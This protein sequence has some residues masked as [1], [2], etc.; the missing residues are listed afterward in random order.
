VVHGISSVSTL[1]HPDLHVTRTQAEV[2]PR[3]ISK[4]LGAGPN[5]TLGVHNGDINTLERALLERMYFCKVG[6]GFSPA[7]NPTYR[8]IDQKLGYF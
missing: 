5:T 2:N 7:P 6:T 4:I 3:R 1:S 8:Y